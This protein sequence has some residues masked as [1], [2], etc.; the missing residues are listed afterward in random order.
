MKKFKELA[1][2]LKRGLFG[3]KRATI[4]TSSVLAVAVIFS[5]LA[6]YVS[7]Y[8][9]RDEAA[10]S[11]FIEG[12]GARVVELYDGATLYG[13][14]DAE[15]GLIFYPGGKV[16]ASAYEPLMRELASRGI[17]SVLIEMPF[18][19]AVLN[20][21][22]ADGII[23]MLPEIKRWYI[24]GH[25]LGGSMAASY[26]ASHTDELEGLVLLGSY[27]TDDISDSGKRVIS[28]Y[29]TEDG[30][31]NRDKYADCKGN[32]PVDYNESEIIGGNHAYFGMYGEQDGD[33]TAQIANGEQIRITA[34]LISDF[35]KEAE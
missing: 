1:G 30:V 14:E 31:M 18:N 6:I 13:R 24:G 25:S 16:E 32:L 5:A 9:H 11:D 35:V 23:D 10:I 12:N 3:S 22:A 8:Y 20:A 2:R 34:S 21:N 19:L 29:G 7:V 15:V 28:V 4:L 17:S 33:G 27:S 26:L